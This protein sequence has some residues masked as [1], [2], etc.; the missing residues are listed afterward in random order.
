MNPTIEGLLNHRSIRKFQ[1]K[2]ISAQTLDTV[3]AAGQAAASSSFIQSTSVIRV[4]DTVIREGLMA[5]SGNQAYVAAAPE[6]LVFVGEFNRSQIACKMHGAELQGG[7]IEQ[8]LIATADAAL[9]AQNCVVAAES[10]GMGICYI[11]ALRNDPARVAALLN[12]PTQSIALFGLCLGYPDQDP[13][14]KPRLPKTLFV[15]ENTYQSP[16]PEAIAEYDQT[17]AQ[18]Y[19]TRGSNL[20]LTDWSSQIA[21]IVGQKETRP[22]MMAFLNSQG[23]ATR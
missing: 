16:T 9:V 17:M 5:V 7:F 8:L 21:G 18:Y 14:T 4:T 19:Q 11:G 1:D 10:L 6:F 2:P 15:H 22:H 12:L 13:E 3:I 23:L 20:K